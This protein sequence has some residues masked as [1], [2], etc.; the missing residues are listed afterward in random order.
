MR[1]LVAPHIK[2]AMER[3]LAIVP[4]PA[5]H[6]SGLTI[7][8]FTLGDPAKV[9]PKNFSTPSHIQA[10][11]SG[12]RGEYFHPRGAP[13][14]LELLGE[15]ETNTE[16][17]LAMNGGSEG[18][19]K[20]IRTLNGHILLPRPC[21]PPYAEGHE[22]HGKPVNMYRVDFEG[23]P[24]LEDMERRITPDTA[25]I[26][27][28]NP[29]NPT[30][31]ANGRKVLEAIIA[32]A[33]KHDL[34]IVADEVY[35]DLTFDHPPPRMRELTTEIPIIEVGSFSKKYLMCG[36]RFGWLAFYNQT[37]ELEEALLKQCGT[38]L[39]ANVPAQLGAI[40][41]IQ[42]GTEHIAPMMNELRIRARLMVDGVSTIPNTR[43]VVPQGGFYFWWG[44]TGTRFEKDLDFTNELGKQEG[45]YILPG[46]G[47]S[48]EQDSS[49]TLW[50]RTV[51][52]SPVDIIS[53]GIDRIAKFVS[54]NS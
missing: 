43:I 1:Q 28:I 24:D 15:H 38:R 39:C 47:F 34:A 54:A 32:L 40:A 53:Q 30:G 37:P 52:L 17:V 36:H 25:A 49:G 13:P 14:L 33:K 27:V 51:F 9:D 5:K 8:N 21:F 31:M 22:Y 3:P 50:F 42:G 12:F 6:P 19:E 48:R 4:A 41:A 10:A 35:H 16:R 11:M 2:Q 44:I 45:V 7:I 46:S 26:L 18:M 29:D 23:G 20:L